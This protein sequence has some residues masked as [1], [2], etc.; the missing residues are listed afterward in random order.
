M[1]VDL[2]DAER[3]LLQRLL[4]REVRELNVEIADTDN[5]AFRDQL[6]GHRD[7]VAA[8]LNRFGGQLPDQER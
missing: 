4:D 2:T 8:L 1:Q 7:A 3:E 6:R 5:S